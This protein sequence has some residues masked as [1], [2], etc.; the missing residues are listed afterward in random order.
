MINKINHAFN[1]SYIKAVNLKKRWL[2]N[3][4]ICKDLSMIKSDKLSLNY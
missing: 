2:T 1:N 4:I 3:I